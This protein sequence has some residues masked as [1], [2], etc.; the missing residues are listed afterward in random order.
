MEEKKESL[1]ELKDLSSIS[2][3]VRMKLMMPRDVEN[4]NNLISSQHNLNKYTWEEHG[5]QVIIYIN[6]LN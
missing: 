4:A 6:N 5:E 3:N 1:N 2:S